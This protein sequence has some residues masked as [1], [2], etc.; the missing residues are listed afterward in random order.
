MG[1]KYLYAQQ[2]ITL[3]AKNAVTTGSGALTYTFEVAS[4][5]AFTTKVAVKDNI[6]AGSGATSVT[7][8][9]ALA[10]GNGYYWRAR[11][12]GGSTPGP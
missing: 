4:D 1:A 2:P 11:S 6:A 8:D 5:A 7:L 3:T 10:G 9:S 12:N